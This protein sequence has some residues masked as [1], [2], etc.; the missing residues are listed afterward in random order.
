MTVDV[1]HI[2]YKFF[3]SLRY[4]VD[5]TERDG[6]II[7]DSALKDRYAADFFENNIVE[8]PPGTPMR[9]PGAKFARKSLGI[10]TPRP[11]SL[12]ICKSPAISQ[13]VDLLCTPYTCS[14][15][16]FCQQLIIYLV[17]HLT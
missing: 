12:Q 16:R 13:C 14:C 8:P 7:G 17:L 15:F 9:V 6:A 11:T 2:N 3:L 4:L 10:A 1:S 5:R